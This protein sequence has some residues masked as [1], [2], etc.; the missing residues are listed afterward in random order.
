M[1]LPAGDKRLVQI[2]DAALADTT[3]RSGKWLTCRPGCTQCCIGVFAISKL[4]ALR[5][6]EGLRELQNENPARAMKVL[7]RARA[8]AER[9]APG[10]PG[11]TRT[12]ILGR[13]PRSQARFEDFANE[14]PCP[15]LDPETG[16]CDLYAARP[17]TCRSF[18]PPVRTQ[19]GLGVCELCFQGAS[20]E[21]I[22]ACEMEVDPGNL[23]SELL[24][25]IGS[26]PNGAEQT[27]VTF[28]L[29]TTI[30]RGKFKL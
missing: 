17:I 6:R 18:G 21:E 29:V 28:A 11:N 4:D 14:E 26:N 23:E 25:Q 5:L 16:L 15:V 19:G 3:R 30:R 13:D 20:E 2:V 27:T 24:R 12:G 7:E 22:A 10:Y 8:S 1:G 9:L